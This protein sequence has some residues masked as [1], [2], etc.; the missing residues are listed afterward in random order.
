MTH[1]VVEAKHGSKITQPR[2]LDQLFLTNLL[3]FINPLRCNHLHFLDLID[4][5][6]VYA[7]KLAVV[8]AKV[9]LMRISQKAGYLLGILF[10]LLAVGHDDVLAQ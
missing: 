9:F 3:V 2:Q 1:T 4:H 6:I 7:H 5:R 8:D 10:R